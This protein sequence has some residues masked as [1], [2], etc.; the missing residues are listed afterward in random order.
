M[1]QAVAQ[2]LKEEAPGDAR[3]LRPARLQV[4]LE[5]NQGLQQAG[6][7]LCETSNIRLSDLATPEVCFN[8]NLHAYKQAMSLVLTKAC[9]RL[10]QFL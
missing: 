9:P 5:L 3:I 10:T 2:R 8:D 6:F 7:F 1:L 4:P